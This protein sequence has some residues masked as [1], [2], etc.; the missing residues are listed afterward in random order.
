M[1]MYLD[2][3]RLIPSTPAAT[4]TT[5]STAT[6]GAGQSTST[7]AVIT[8]ADVDDWTS[9]QKKA[10]SH[11]RLRVGDGPMAYIRNTATGAEA[12]ETLESI[13]RPKGAISIIHVQ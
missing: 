12:W 13:Y 7:T 11:I 8:Q 1:N 6:K 10:L 5:S 9:K 2:L 4:N 3:K